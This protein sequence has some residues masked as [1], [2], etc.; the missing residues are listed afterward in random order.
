MS[1]IVAG[2]DTVI[3]CG[4]DLQGRLIGRRVPAERFESVCA[5][6]VA[7]CTCVFGWDIAQSPHLLATGALPYTGMHNGMGDFLLVPDTETLRPATW[8]DS[9]AICFGDA[10]ELDGAPT[11]LSPRHVL[12]EQVA[13]LAAD[14]YTASVGT[15]LELY[16]FRGHPRELADAGFAELVP[17]H[18]RPADFAIAEGDE[19]EP[20]FGGLRRRL[21]AAGIEVEASQVEWGLG[22][23]E[24]TLVHTSPVEMADRHVLYKL[25][26]R[27][28]A[29]DAGMTATFMA[30]PVDG[31]P[32][33]SCHVH[34]SLR[35]AN[36]APVFWHADSPHRVSDRLR[37]AIAGALEHAPDLMAWYA[38]TVNS[39][40][41]VRSQDA[42]GWGQTW[43]IDHRFT[44]VRVVGHTPASIRLEFRLPGADT[45]P[46]LTLA[47]LLASIRSGLAGALDPG[48]PETG[49]P[50][51]RPPGAIPQH[52]GEAVERFAASDWVRGV[53][54]DALVDHYATLG[55]F[56]W[57]QFLDGVT[58]WERRRY[59]DVI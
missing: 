20:F 22:Q 46:Y 58:D 17:T 47:G 6:G 44:S 28:A 16:L 48:P 37:H 53:F 19:L 41:R 12:A 54:G 42:A 45:N 7:V 34:L 13:A 3:V 29:A 9:T 15:E 30:K 43:G 18:V 35:D 57:E 55:R 38:P 23:W 33:S 2:V 27:R 24:T 52:L 36:G 8:L 1:R 51:E 50:Y 5:E 21:V 40:R 25:A 59:L 10:T 14:G 26:T 32:G 39:Y 31:Q 11:A 49:N 4:P 56:E